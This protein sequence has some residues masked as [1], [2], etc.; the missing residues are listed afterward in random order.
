MAVSFSVTNAHSVGDLRSVHGTFTSAAGDSSASLS[1][2]THGL[3]Y[4]ADYT[5]TLDTG[6]VSSHNPKVTVSSGTL[7]IVFEDTQG[8]SGK[9]YV[10]GR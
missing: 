3:D 1:N 7:T 8:Y 2:S 4:I 10:K 5:V 9:W 6:G